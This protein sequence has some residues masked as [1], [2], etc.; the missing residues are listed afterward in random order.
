[1]RVISIVRVVSQLFKRGMLHHATLS[2][3][4][5]FVYHIDKPIMHL[6]PVMLIPRV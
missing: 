1:M 4:V 2:C 6:S 3:Y 5:M